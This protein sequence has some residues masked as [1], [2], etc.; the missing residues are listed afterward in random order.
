MPDASPGLT[1]GIYPGMTGVEEANVV[2]PGPHHDDPMKTKAAL[3]SLEAAGRPLLVRGYLIYRGGDHAASAT[4]VDL[5]VYADAGRQLDVV[6]CYRSERGD[7]AEWSGYVRRMVAR[8]GPIADAIQVT[9]E[10]NNPLTETGGDGSAPKVRQAMIEGTIAAKEE[11]VA[12]HLPVKV[13]VAFAPSFNPADDFWPDVGRRISP[14][15]LAS[16]DYVGLDFF[17]DVFRPVSFE[18]IGEAV[19]G[20]LV[21]FR[22]ANLRAGGIPE[23]ADPDH[24]ERLADGPGPT[25]RAA[26]GDPRSGRADDPPPPGRPEHHPLRMVP[27]PGWRFGATGDGLPVGA[28]PARL[29]SQTGVRDV[30]AAHRRVGRPRPCLT[31]RWNGPGPPSPP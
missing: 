14:E 29:H 5:S 13:G 2:V 10:P 22:T 4:P 15:F 26:S 18:Q 16:L 17:P 7:L 9:E 20:V 24:R 3:T 11:A 28:A 30:P 23:S 21:H 31:S 25:A 19:E 8:F 27:A 6:L 12:R 1:F